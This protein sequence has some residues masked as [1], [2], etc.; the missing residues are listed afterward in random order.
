[1]RTMSDNIMDRLDDLTRSVEFIKSKMM[2]YECDQM[3]KEMKQDQEDE[4]AG[5][6]SKYA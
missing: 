6:Q 5:G 3:S 1:M 2:K 4:L